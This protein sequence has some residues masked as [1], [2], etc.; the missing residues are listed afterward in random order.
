MTDPIALPV[1]RLPKQTVHQVWAP[2]LNRTVVLA[3]RDQ[4][5]L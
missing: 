4:L 5:H 1:N 2:K 3:G